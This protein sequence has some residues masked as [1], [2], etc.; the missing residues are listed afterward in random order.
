MHALVEKKA[1]APN[2]HCDVSC[3]NDSQLG[4]R[5]GSLNPVLGRG[6]VL[7]AHCDTRRCLLRGGVTGSGTA[8]AVAL[9]FESLTVGN[10]GCGPQ[11]DNGLLG[12]N[13]GSTAQRDGLCA[14]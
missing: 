8:T 14:A 2:E 13:H 1:L 3:K 5:A 12:W 4:L 11:P 10:S 6:F 7:C 9:Q